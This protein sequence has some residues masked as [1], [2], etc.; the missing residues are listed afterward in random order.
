M[1]DVETWVEL[2]LSWLLNFSCVGGWG[3]GGW[4]VG[5]WVC[6]WVGVE[7]E[8]KADWSVQLSCSWSWSL[9]LA[10]RLCHPKFLQKKITQIILSKLFCLPPNY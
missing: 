3:S 8:V 7:N 4:C 1:V 5:G 10:I 2:V 9:S 6:G